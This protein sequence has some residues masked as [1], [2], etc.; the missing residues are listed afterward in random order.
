MGTKLKIDY[1]A[2]DK[3]IAEIKAISNNINTIIN[4]PLTTSDADGL[5]ADAL[6]NSFYPKLQAVFLGLKEPIDSFV[7]SLTNTKN[8]YYNAETAAAQAIKN[9]EFTTENVAGVTEE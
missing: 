7:E 9:I 4:A 8:N 5:I 3:G 2:F 6:N 1:E